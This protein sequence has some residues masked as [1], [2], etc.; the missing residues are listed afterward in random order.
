MEKWYYKLCLFSR[1]V[2][3]S[4]KHTKHVKSLNNLILN[5]KLNNNIILIKQLLSIINLILIMINITTH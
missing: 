2:K 3:V 1:W 4:L 5:N